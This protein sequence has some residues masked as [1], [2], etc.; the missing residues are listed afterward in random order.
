MNENDK[1]REIIRLSAQ[2]NTVQD[3]DILL[4]RILHEAR[5]FTNADAGTIYIRSGCNLVFSHAQNDTLQKKLPAGSKLIYST[6][7]IPINTSSIAGFVAAKGEILNLTDAYSLPPD[8]PYK[9][10]PS[11]DDL[12]QYKTVSV[13]TVPL[14]TEI[15]KI[16]G[17]LQMINAKNETGD[18]VSF[19]E[20]DELY[21]YHFASAASMVLQRAQMTRTLL[22]RMIQMAQLRDPKETGPHVNR[23]AS[24][25]VELYEKWANRRGLH[26]HD[27]DTNRDIL[28][29][30]AVLHDVGKVGISDLILKKPGKL[31]DY[32]YNIMK[33]HTTIGA[34]LFHDSQSEFDEAA[35]LVSLTHHEN[36]DGTGYPGMIDVSTGEILE[37]DSK[38]NPLPRRGEDI[39]IYGRIVALAD[40]FDALSSRRVFKESWE[41]E[42]VLK[43]IKNL[44][45]TKF[46]PEIVDIFFDSIDIIR[47]IIN[48]YPDQ[49]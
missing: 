40:V 37:R 10:D 1:L 5:S 27:I 22:L 4:E 3:V 23:V 46:D 30:A 31:D 39:H 45:G 38:G 49:S 43:E 8:V 20:E 28:R 12:A 11:Y 18:I 42:R 33:T 2:L 16:I 13:L 36:W 48:K 6:F 9:F 29:M 17:V 26:P 21:V 32:E 14:K 24:Y 7:R 15:G 19:D 34:N 44:S 35:A 41:E 25:S 47:S